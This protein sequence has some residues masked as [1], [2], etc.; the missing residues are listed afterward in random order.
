VQY[1]G[2]VAVPLLTSGYILAGG[3]DEIRILLIMKL[4]PALLLNISLPALSP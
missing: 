1:T 4:D 3:A 2:T